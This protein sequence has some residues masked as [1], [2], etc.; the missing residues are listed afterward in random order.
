MLIDLPITR[1]TYQLDAAGVPKHQ[2]SVDIIV[3]V[4]NALADVQHCLEI[5]KTI[6]ATMPALTRLTY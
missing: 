6:C 5:L 1:P 3:C 4:H 2:Q